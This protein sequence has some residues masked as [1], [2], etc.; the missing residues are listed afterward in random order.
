MAESSQGRRGAAFGAVDDPMQK[1][2]AIAGC[3]VLR[4]YGE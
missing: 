3:G 1:A 2:K 4:G